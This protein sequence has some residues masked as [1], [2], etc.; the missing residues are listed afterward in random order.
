MNLQHRAVLACLMEAQG[1]CCAYCW[2]PLAPVA[3]L[4][5]QR[6]PMRPTVDH[7]IPREA[8]GPDRPGNWLAAHAR[9]NVVKDMNMPG[10]ETVEV[11]EA[12]NIIL[13]WRT[14]DLSRWLSFVPSPALKAEAA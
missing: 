12:V 4:R 10:P 11:L 5:N 9:C 13:G 7:V 8:G 14:P 1:N 6:D 3:S 2:R